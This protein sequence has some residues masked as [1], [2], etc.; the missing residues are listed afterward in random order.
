MQ[1]ELILNMTFLTKNPDKRKRIVELM[2]R[3][4][5]LP[6]KFIPGFG[7][8]G[9]GYGSVDCTGDLGVKELKALIEYFELKLSNKVKED[10]YNAGSR[11]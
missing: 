7:M 2:Q 9:K 10:K 1:I 11:I 4:G 3:D 5:E 6:P 8:S